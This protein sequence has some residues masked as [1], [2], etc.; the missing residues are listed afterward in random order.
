VSAVHLLNDRLLKD[1]WRRKWEKSLDIEISGS[2]GF[3]L[4]KEV[5]EEVSVQCVA[6]PD[7]LPKGK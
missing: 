1:C 7:T 5:V 3:V 2:G 6:R 4:K